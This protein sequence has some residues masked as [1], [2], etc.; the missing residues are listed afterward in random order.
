[1]FDREDVIKLF[2]WVLVWDHSE[3]QNADA[4]WVLLRA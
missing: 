1:M 4:W 3:M 2:H